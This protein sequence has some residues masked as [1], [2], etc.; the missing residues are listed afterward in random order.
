MIP[1]IVFIL[2]KQF[3]PTKKGQEKWGVSPTVGCPFTWGR[4]KTLLASQIDEFN[5]TWWGSW[6]F[7]QLQSG[8]LTSKM[9]EPLSHQLVSGRNPLWFSWGWLR[10]STS[11]SQ[12]FPNLAG[13]PPSQWI[14]IQLLCRKSMKIPPFMLDIIQK[15]TSMGQFPLPGD[16]SITG[17]LKQ[18]RIWK[19]S[20]QLSPSTHHQA[21]R[22]WGCWRHLRAWELCTCQNEDLRCW[23]GAEQ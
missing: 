10:N 14:E 18:Y 13:F 5:Q 15:W 3:F 20:Y 4:V 7:I 22:V 1:L 17:S 11:T 16:R 6:I 12:K 2:Q 19:T 8:F 21:T 9:W 23:K